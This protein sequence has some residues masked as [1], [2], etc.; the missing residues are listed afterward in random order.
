MYHVVLNPLTQIK[1]HN[2]C[3]S[4]SSSTALFDAQEFQDLFDNLDTICSEPEHRAYQNHTL[5]SPAPPLSCDS[6]F[7]SAVEFEK[8]VSAINLG[9]DVV[10]PGKDFSRNID[11]LTLEANPDL[12]TDS[13]L[14]YADCA[15][16]DGGVTRSY[17]RRI[18]KTF[19]KTKAVA[20][21]CFVQE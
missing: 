15:D 13:G 21:N 19:S 12:V 5:I 9:K 3:S 7:D 2:Y 18:H 1:R 17:P 6:S 20:S 14:V 8:I 16:A 10:P 11:S 4:T